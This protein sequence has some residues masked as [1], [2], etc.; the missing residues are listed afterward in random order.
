[1]HVIFVYFSI[2]G[3][4]WKQIAWVSVSVLETFIG[5]FSH[6]AVDAIL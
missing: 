3:L 5:V 2:F 1:M 4:S 6:I